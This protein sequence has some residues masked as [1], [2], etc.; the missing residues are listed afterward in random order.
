[1]LMQ[2]HSRRMVLAV[3]DY[4]PLKSTAGESRAASVIP[5]D[6][7]LTICRLILKAKIIDAHIKS[8]DKDV[9]YD[10][11]NIRNVTVTV[12]IQKNSG[13][14]QM[15]SISRSKCSDVIH[16][17]SSNSTLKTEFM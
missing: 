15:D 11:F 3:D 9:E 5:R 6:G 14:I 13:D 8:D 2:V 1:M 4:L 7:A 17:C 16:A 12:A 10:R